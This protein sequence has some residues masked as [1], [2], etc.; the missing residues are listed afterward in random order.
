MISGTNQPK[1]T[2]TPV[3]QVKGYARQATYGVG[4]YG[5]AIYGVGTP[6]FGVKTNQTKSGGVA[7]F[8]ITDEGDFLIT[9]EGYYLCS[10][11]G[12]SVTNQLKS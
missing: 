8:L 10:S 9:D 11:T 3:G 5:I 7:T 4:V 6:G 12:V 1:N 2:V